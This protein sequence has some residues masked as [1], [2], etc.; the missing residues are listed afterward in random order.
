MEHTDTN[1]LTVRINNGTTQVR[2][3]E[4]EDQI[5]FCFSQCH[6]M[7]YSLS[8]L[9]IIQTFFYTDGAPARFTDHSLPGTEQTGAGLWH[10]FGRTATR[11]AIDHQQSHRVFELLGG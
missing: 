5:T 11:I 3:L 10:L 2:A 6:V 7:L 1:E 4:P 8:I 9:F